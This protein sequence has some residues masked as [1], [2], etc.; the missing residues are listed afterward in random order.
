M[1]TR[2]EAAERIRNY[3][4][5]GK[6]SGTIDVNQKGEPELANKGHEVAFICEYLKN[7]ESIENL[8]TFDSLE[9]LTFHFLMLVIS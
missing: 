3:S 4:E 6:A 2:K 8:E 1:K 7:F 9:N 5:S